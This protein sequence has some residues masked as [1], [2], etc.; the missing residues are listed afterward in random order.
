M[1]AGMS[2]WFLLLLLVLVALLLSTVK[3]TFVL[4]LCCCIFMEVFLEAVFVVFVLNKHAETNHMQYLWKGLM[5]S[6]EALWDAVSTSFLACFSVS[7]LIKLQL[8]GAQLGF[9]CLILCVREKT[10]LYDQ[11]H[12]FY[13]CVCVWSS[14]SG[15][16]QLST[17]LTVDFSPWILIS[18]SANQIRDLCSGLWTW[19]L[20]TLH[21]VS[22]RKTA[23]SPQT[24]H[25]LF[26]SSDSN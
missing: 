11:F 2:C 21:L 23:H 19:T 26:S 15:S 4:N 25:S 17:L 5:S 20:L 8:G 18:L 9:V 12:L 10:S 24:H 16:R 3:C 14:S 6:T 1:E 22:T 13:L 7:R